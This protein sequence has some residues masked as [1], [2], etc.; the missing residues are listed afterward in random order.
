MTRCREQVLTYCTCVLV[1]L[2]RS[3]GAREPETKR[4]LQCP[5]SF[6]AVC[7]APTR[8]VAADNNLF[9]CR[10]L[11]LL[12]QAAGAAAESSGGGAPL[13]RASPLLHRPPRAPTVSARRA[14]F[15]I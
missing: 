6:S 9:T 12:A 13:W 3:I 11:A 4:R 5:W 7:W 15:A 8:L 14:R 1:G 2:R 10:T